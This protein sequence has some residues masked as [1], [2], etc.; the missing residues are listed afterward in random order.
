LSS[1][2]GYQVS[3]AE[4]T[5]LAAAGATERL[6]GASIMTR[7]TLKHLAAIAIVCAT[8]SSVTSAVGNGL[9]FVVDE[10]HV[11][12]AF[13]NLVNADSL[14]LTYHSCVNFIQQGVFQESGYFW[15]SSYQEP[16]SVVDSQINYIGGNG[17]RIYGKYHYQAQFFNGNQPT[18]TGVRFNYVAANGEPFIELFLDPQSNT[19]LDLQECAPVPIGGINDDIPIGSSVTL[20]YGEKSETNGV[21]N[22][23]FEL[24]FGNWTFTNFGLEMFSQPADF[25]RLVFNANLTTLTG[26]LTNDHLAEGS[27]NLFWRP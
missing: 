25:N 6:E 21:A 5:V 11:P 24:R 14:D 12:D 18:P 17:Y 9:P 10:D 8:A 1:A 20:N 13:G 15:V 7:K 2:G 16:G 22:G 23:D 19:V 3:A 4:L 27:G 26:P